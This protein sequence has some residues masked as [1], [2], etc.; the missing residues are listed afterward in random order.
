M[1][2]IKCHGCDLV[3]FSGAE[4]CKRCGTPLAAASWHFGAGG[5]EC[6]PAARRMGSSASKLFLAF[7]A[8]G[9]LVGA[10]L[11]ARQV[12]RAQAESPFAEMIRG[13]R[14]FA[15]PMTVKV[16]QEA[17][18]EGAEMWGRYAAPEAYVLA[19]LGLMEVKDRHYTVEVQDPYGW[20]NDRLYVMGLI[21]RPRP[22]VVKKRTVDMALTEAGR[23]AA[24]GWSAVVE[25]RSGRGIVWWRVPVGRRELVSI[26]SADPAP[27]DPGDPEA[28]FVHFKWRWRPNEVGAAFDRSGP[29][30]HLLP[31]EARDSALARRDSAAVYDGIGSFTRGADGGWKLDEVFCE[32]EFDQYTGKNIPVVDTD[33]P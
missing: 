15:E 14:Q 13:S 8:F 11:A 22:I 10:L 2:G 20:R 1:K 12:R 33:R 23:A 30:R 25:E 16:N 3:N 28:L 29:G 6:A 7:V 19:R 9:L 26:A 18:P 24:A 31:D 5:R 17:L 27:R 4:N 32:V 21:D